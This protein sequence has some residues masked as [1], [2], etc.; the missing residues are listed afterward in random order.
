MKERAE[1]SSSDGTKM[2]VIS[3]SVK[4]L[5]VDEAG[6]TMDEIDEEE[7]KESGRIVFRKLGSVIESAY[8]DVFEMIFCTHADSPD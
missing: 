6:M 2:L 3:L 8:G 5:P 1:S 7:K 4:R